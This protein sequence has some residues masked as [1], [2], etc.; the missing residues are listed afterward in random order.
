LI[1]TQELAVNIAT[2]GNWRVHSLDIRLFDQ[3][4]LGQVTQLQ[5]F[6][7]RERL[8]LLELGD[9]LVEV[10]RHRVLCLVAAAASSGARASTTA[11]PAAARAWPLR[12]LRAA[13]LSAGLNRQGERGHSCA[14]SQAQPATSCLREQME[15]S[16]QL[17]SA[18]A[19]A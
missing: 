9:A 7:L 19:V 16:G 8:A 10:E 14:I 12:V 15:I 1:S 3:N 5:H 18:S 11:A 6:V 13:R 2:N 17:V 4:L